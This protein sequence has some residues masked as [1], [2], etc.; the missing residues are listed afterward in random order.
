MAAVALQSSE[1]VVDEPEPSVIA[2]MVTVFG[3]AWC[4]RISEVTIRA[5]EMA[6]EDLSEDEIQD[7]GKLALKRF[8]QMPSPAEVLELLNG[9]AEQ[10]AIAAWALVLKAQNHGAYKHVDFGDKLINA[11]IR[12]LGGWVQMF[13]LCNTPQNESYYRHRFIQVYVSLSA[14]KQLSEE[15]VR[16]LA[17]LNEAEGGRDKQPVPICIGAP[18]APPN[19]L[20][21]PMPAEVVEV[22]AIKRP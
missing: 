12:A 5:Y 22:L 20:P 2:R 8:K 9:S 13:D 4:R 1:Y 6:L 14:A 17:G 21:R 7:V 15:A 10:H 19:L 3:E 11:S 18:K 16:P